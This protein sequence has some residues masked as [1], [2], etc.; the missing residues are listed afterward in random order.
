MILSDH[1]GPPSLTTHQH[2]TTNSVS[3]SKGEERA[4]RKI[5]QPPPGTSSQHE[6]V[7][8]ELGRYQRRT[9]RAEALITSVDL[10]GTN[11]RRVK[12]PMLSI[13]Y[14]RNQVQTTET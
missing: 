1:H 11:T 10:A 3:K 9:K 5:G 6:K 12:W 2:K 13:P 4:P 7:S 8:W 14:M